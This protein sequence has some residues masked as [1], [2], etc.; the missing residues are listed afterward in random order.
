MHKGIKR[1]ARLLGAFAKLRKAT[2]SFVMSVRPSARMEQLGS[3]WIDFHEIWYLSN[4]RN[5]VEKYSRLT[6]IGQE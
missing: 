3:H 2:I 5:S 6:A 4:T 1:V